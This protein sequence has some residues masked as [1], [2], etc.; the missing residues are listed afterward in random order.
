MASSFQLSVEGINPS[1]RTFQGSESGT[2]V[3]LDDGSYSVREPGIVS[4]YSIASSPDCS[5]SISAGQTKTCT[6]TNTAHFGKISIDKN[7]VGGT[8]NKFQ[9]TLRVTFSCDPDLNCG[10]VTSGGEFR[11]P[12]TFTLPAS[13]YTIT[14]VSTSSPPGYTPTYSDGCS[15]HLG[16]GETKTCIVT[17]TFTGP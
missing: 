16:S 17:N 8:A 13:T 12:N 11:A 15:G 10:G 7:V 2:A 6:V 4:G 5:G 9:F 1:P 14:E 3:T